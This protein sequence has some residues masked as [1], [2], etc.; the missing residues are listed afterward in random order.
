MDFYI[1]VAISILN[2]FLA[3]FILFRNTRKKINIYFSITVFGIFLW[4]LSIAFFRVVGLD[5]SYFWGQLV[6]FSVNF[7]IVFF[8]YFSFVFP[9]GFFPKNKLLYIVLIGLPVLIF[10]VSFIP[11]SIISNIEVINGRNKD[12]YFNWGYYIH[13]V[14]TIIFL[15]WAFTNLLFK[16]KK[17]SGIQKNQLLYLFSGCAISVGIAVVTNIILPFFGNASLNWV[18]PACTIFMVL[19]VIYAITRYRLMD[20]K[21][22]VARTLVFSLIVLLITCIY[23]VFSAVIG[24]FFENL[25]GIK[26][27]IGVG[28]IISILVV[29]G[30]SRLRKFIERITNTFLFKKSY[31]A[32]ALLSQI[33]EVTSSILNFHQLLASIS[34]TLDDA[35]HCEKIAVGLLDKTGKLHLAYQQGFDPGVMEK[36]TAGKEQVLPLYFTDSREIQVIDELKS[37]YEAGE[38]QPKNVELLEGLY[39]MDIGLVIPLFV[40]EKLIGLF[41]LGNK[42]SGDPYSHQ[43]LSIIKIIAGQSAIAIE[44]A[45]LYDELK[46]YNI[47]LDEE[48][49]KK[50]AELRQANEELKRL[51]EAKSEFISI[52]SHQLRTPLTIIKGYISMMLEGS[53]G[54]ISL[55]VSANLT[56]VYEANERLIRLVENL[57]D[58]SRIES[59]RQEYNMVDTRLEDMAKVVVENLKANAAAKKL[60]LVFSLPDKKLPAVHADID[61][62]HEVMINFVDNAI[63][64]TPAGKVEVSVAEEPKGM[65]T[66]CVKDSGMGISPEIK[67]SLFH[68]FSRSKDSFRAH[69]EGLGLGLYVAKMMIDAHGGK[70]WAE[71]DGEGKGSKFCFSLPAVAALIKPL[72]VKT[73]GSVKVKK[74][75]KAKK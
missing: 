19:F 30:Y 16:F 26:S 18:G 3:A 7:T 74:S 27:S 44:N 41:V 14:V 38:Y 49:K 66:F 21:F 22:V 13:S 56:K 50:T 25:V 39:N 61:K 51:D 37:R 42:K 55:A 71:S 72:A 43:D 67:A 35:F 73:A 32:D 75:N 11:K 1:P 65:V 45:T 63:K 12:L 24:K 23:V 6:Y 46:D 64:Y 33:S 52:A 36:F 20:I 54:E 34:G 28:V 59:G 15:I 4:S 47:K 2:L 57:L 17:A 70:I 53:F 60:Q 8:L 40:K 68:K 5:A 31:D 9:T 48:V 10:I 69:T 29:A 62:L 58:I